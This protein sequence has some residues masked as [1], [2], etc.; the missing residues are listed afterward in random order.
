MKKRHMFWLGVAGMALLAFITAKA[1]LH[2]KSSL[3]T[4]QYLT[5]GKYYDEPILWRV[6]NTGEDGSPLLLTEHIISL[7]AFDAKGKEGTHGLSTMYGSNYWPDSNIRLWLN[8]ASGKVRWLHN[9]PTAD[10]LCGGMNPY[11]DESGFLC[12]PNFSGADRSAI[13]LTRRKVTL[14]EFEKDRRE[15]GSEAHLQERKIPI[16]LRNYDKAYYQYTEDKVFFLTLDEI[17]HLFYEKGLE[18]R[19]KPTA[20]AV[21]YSQYDIPV[22]RVD[23]YWEFYLMDPVGDSP[24]AVRNV[25]WDTDIEMSMAYQVGGVRPAMVL[26]P[27]KILITGG[28]GTPEDPFRVRGKSL[29]D[30]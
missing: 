14:S 1:L 15:G 30:F 17:Y 10:Y 16:A 12:G 11:A 26:D 19:A 24:C 4:G 23:R 2:T 25:I 18:Y 5:F 29:F 28:S 8:S 13:R 7:K 27:G 22:K 3:E 6:I 21:F 20:S 9:P